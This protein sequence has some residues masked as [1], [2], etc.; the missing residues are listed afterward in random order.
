MKNVKLP[1][2]ERVGYEFVGYKDENGNIYTNNIAQIDFKGSKLLESVWK[3]KEY[4]LTLEY[5]NGDEYQ[6]LIVEF[7][8]KYDLPT[9]EMEKGEE[10]VGWMQDGNILDNNYC[11]VNSEGDIVLVASIISSDEASTDIDEIDGN[12]NNVII[13]GIIALFVLIIIA[14]ILYK[15]KVSKKVS[16][17]KV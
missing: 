10:F 9:P 17:N 1:V 13:G 12:T 7:G 2:P 11:V 5:P 16:N 6:S 15:K 14:I 4:Q 3:A 8:Q